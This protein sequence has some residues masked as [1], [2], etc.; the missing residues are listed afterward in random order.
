MDDLTEDQIE[1][2]S[3]EAE[4]GYTRDAEGRW[5]SNMNRLLS[6]T[7]AVQWAAAFVHQFNGDSIGQ[8][9]DEVTL[10][11][12]FAVAIETGR[13]AGRRELCPHPSDRLFV[14]GDLRICRVCG[15]PVT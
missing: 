6:T 14:E 11:T 13:T 8:T 3:A 2:L 9:L 15:H 1:A 10:R 7:D 4:M 12:W 5:G